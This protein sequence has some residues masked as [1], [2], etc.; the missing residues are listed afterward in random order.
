MRNVSLTSSVRNEVGTN[1][2]HRVRRSGNVPGIIYGHNFTNYPLVFDYGTLNKFIRDNGENAMVNVLINNTPHTAMIKEVQ[3]DI[4]SGEITHIDLQQVNISEKIHTS[5]PILLSGKD[6]IDDGVLQQQVMKLD[7]ECYPTDVPKNISIDI[8]KLALGDTFRVSD[9][10]M[11][12]EIAVLNDMEEIIALVSG[13]DD[14]RLDEDEEVLDPQPN[15]PV[16]EVR[17]EGEEDKAHPSGE[18]K[19]VL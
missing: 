16:P 3:R 4:I 19:I 15:E 5:I 14:H 10:E 17:D 1:A 8:S 13:V 2:S 12:E 18:E 11:G 6:K 9:V 7:V